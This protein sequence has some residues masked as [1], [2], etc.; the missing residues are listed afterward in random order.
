MPRV[1]KENR[2]SPA[3]APKA[4]EMAYRRSSERKS[5]L[6]NVTNNSNINHIDSVVESVENAAKRL[7]QHSQHSNSSK[8][9]VE[10]KIGPWRLGRTLGKGS[11]GRVRLGK[12]VKTGMLAAIKIIPKQKGRNSLPYGI[13]REII[14]MK[15]ITH[16]N[17]MALY[18]VWENDNELYLVLEYVQ[19]GE[20]FD[21]IINN[22]KLNEYDAIKYFKMIINGVSYC[23]KFNICHRDLKPENILMD[24]DGIIKIADFG[25]AALETNQR[26]LETSCGSPHYA[27]P[28]I[29]TGKNYHGSPSDVWSCGVILFA[30]LTGHL[31]FDDKS[32]RKL[33]LKVQSG[34]FFMPQNLSIEAKDLIWSMLRVNPSERIPINQIMNHPLL[35]KYPTHQSQSNDSNDKVLLKL[36]NIDMS[37]PVMDIDSDI[38]HNL[39]TLWHGIPKSRIILMLKMDGQNNEKM[40]YYL[41]ENYKLDHIGK[42]QNEISIKKS[43]SQL[44]AT[45]PRSTSTVKTVIEDE[46]GEILK[47]VVQ[48]FKSPPSKLSQKGNSGKRKIK[49]IVASSSKKSFSSSISIINMNQKLSSRPDLKSASINSIPNEILIDTKTIKPNAN[50]K[51]E[52]NELHEFK[53]LMN[54][55]FEMPNESREGSPNESRGE[56]P[57]ESKDGSTN[58][59][60][61]GSTNDS[62]LT[63]LELLKLDLK[64]QNPP[65][66][67]GNL[68][69]I[70]SSSTRKLSNY[71]GTPNTSLY[72]YNDLVKNEKHDRKESIDSS[73]LNLS[74][75]FHQGISV[76]LKSPKEEEI[77]KFDQQDIAT[78]VN[79][80]SIY[81]DAPSKL[82]IIN[83]SNTPIIDNRGTSTTTSPIP[84][85]IKSSQRVPIIPQHNQEK[86]E[87][88]R[89]GYS[90]REKLKVPENGNKKINWFR[91]IINNIK[92]NAKKGVNKL[93][94]HEMNQL[95]VKKEYWLEND[96]INSEQ[97]FNDIKNYSKFKGFKIKSTRKNGSQTL[98]E[99]KN[100]STKMFIKMDLLDKIGNEF[101]FTGCFI[102][103]KLINGSIK[104]FD[105][106]CLILN[107]R[108]QKLG[109]YDYEEA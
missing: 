64:S 43:K 28:E 81:V 15:L 95:R 99:L 61:E 107:D 58:E 3:L 4:A 79:E 52:L 87:F 30:L 13:E 94:N 90:P 10:N 91:K 55:I 89:K 19:G 63:K 60:R 106:L 88:P 44:I 31:P 105:D 102:N 29:V 109:N 50:K 104:K 77:I 53:Y 83:E 26:L 97:F 67:S 12:H 78:S 70:K 98:I 9:K 100:S 57:D 51:S 5:I 34:K 39:Q 54:S 27:S 22:G 72:D 17:I 11:T 62:K 23:H 48:E 82:S 37:K 33:L 41:L 80:E 69:R 56:S 32:I 59:L 75:S 103:L 42:I 86:S 85:L 84:E 2:A 108:L 68:K 20:L 38:L 49:P 7:S 14:I 21:F 74:Y 24:K 16:P 96:F 65:N 40:F 71:L 45:L 46:N 47:S 93:K 36:Q 6:H 101:G 25:M 76:E 8:R 35:L 1:E 73:Y 18:D 66:S 92:I